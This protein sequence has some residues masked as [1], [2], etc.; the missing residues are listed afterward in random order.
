MSPTG[1][2]A[3]GAATAEA[4]VVNPFSGMPTQS[5]TASADLFGAGAGPG[6]MR[7]SDDLLALSGPNPF[8]GSVP[9]PT[10]A[11]VN[12]FNSPTGAAPGWPNSGTCLVVKSCQI[13]S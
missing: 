11:A 9:Q 4:P 8:V 10:V 1:D 2:K 7:P 12:P 13:S 5:P 3:G 6:A